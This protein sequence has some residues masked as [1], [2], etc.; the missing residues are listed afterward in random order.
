[1]TGLSER[2]HWVHNQTAQFLSSCAQNERITNMVN[3]PWLIV[4][5]RPQNEK[6]N[7]QGT[8][9]N[10]IKIK[11]ASSQADHALIHFK[12]FE[13]KAFMPTATGLL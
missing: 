10:P 13:N 5:H 9:T 6:I 2:S 1:M 11:S 7:Q 4:A 12:D 3:I 8:F